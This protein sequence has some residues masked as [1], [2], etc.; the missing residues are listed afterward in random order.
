VSSK[1]YQG[2]SQVYFDTPN[3]IGSASLKLTTSDREFTLNEHLHLEPNLRS[4]YDGD[5]SDLGGLVLQRPIE[6]HVDWI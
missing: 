3:E 2:L 6:P 1:V 5:L 4:S